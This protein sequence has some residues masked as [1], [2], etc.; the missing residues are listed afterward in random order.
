MVSQRMTGSAFATA[1]VPTSASVIHNFSPQ[2]KDLVDTG[3]LLW[4]GLC[5]SES[6][7][8]SHGEKL[9]DLLPPSFQK[10]NGASENWAMHT[11]GDCINQSGSG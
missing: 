9:R 1:A 6:L 8:L 7:F 5:V 10:A 3:N 2:I 11:I 4:I